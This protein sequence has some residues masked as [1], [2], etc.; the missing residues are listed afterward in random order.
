MTCFKESSSDNISSI[1][2]F[3]YTFPSRAHDY[4]FTHIIN[5]LMYVLI[6]MYIGVYTIV[7]T[8]WYLTKVIYQAGE[9]E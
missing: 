6:N 9:E 3:R 8:D 2:N 7:C 4:F 1:A 5:V